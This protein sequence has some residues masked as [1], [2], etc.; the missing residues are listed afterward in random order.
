MI[1]ITHHTPVCI[2]KTT[3]WPMTVKMFVKLLPN[4]RQPLLSV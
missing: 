4:K 3:S 1:M 2:R